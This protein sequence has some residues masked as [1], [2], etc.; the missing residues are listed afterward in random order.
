[1]LV[2]LTAES[3]HFTPNTKENQYKFQGRSLRPYIQ[4]LT[5]IGPRRGRRNV[6]SDP[7]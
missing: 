5:A 4:K 1:M 6:S 7:L 2:L 3:A